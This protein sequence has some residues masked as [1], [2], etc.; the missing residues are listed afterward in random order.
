MIMK[1][2]TPL[3][4]WHRWSRASAL[5]SAAIVAFAITCGSTQL[6]AQI[7]WNGA[8]GDGNWLTAGNWIGGAIPNATTADAVVG[9]P[10]P[11]LLNGNIDINSL[12]VDAAGV[13][14]ID[15]SRNLDFGGTATTTLNNAGTINVRNN[16]D[17]QFQ[18]TVINRGDINV[19]AG[20]SSSD[21]EI[22]ALGASLDGRHNHAQWRQRWDSQ[23]NP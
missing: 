17:L 11:V 7:T 9:A 21:I 1:N 18:N 13:V 6:Q 2:E 15:T 4:P 23:P 3:L 5:A 10:S 8:D 14:T 20:T 16:A 19:N 22:D 12:T